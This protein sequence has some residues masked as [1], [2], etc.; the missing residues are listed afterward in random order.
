MLSFL[1]TALELLGS[2]GFLIRIS[3]MLLLF[4]G[5]RATAIDSLLLL[6]NNLT[7]RFSPYNGKCSVMIIAHFGASVITKL[8]AK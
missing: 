2:E 1:Y 3:M 5:S 4:P 6:P 8:N 7:A